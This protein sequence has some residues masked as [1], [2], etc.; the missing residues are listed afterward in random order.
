MINFGMQIH[1]DWTYPMDLSNATRYNY[2]VLLI[3]IASFRALDTRGKKNTRKAL[4]ASVKRDKRIECGMQI[5][6]DKL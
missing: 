2:C 6:I 5:H 1:T 4:K 3:K